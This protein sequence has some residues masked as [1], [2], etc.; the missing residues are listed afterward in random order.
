M[1]IIAAAFWAF[2]R[3]AVAVIILA[4][5]VGFLKSFGATPTDWTAFVIIALSALMAY[6]TKPEKS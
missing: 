5:F 3:F 4:G 1:K 2:I 6:F